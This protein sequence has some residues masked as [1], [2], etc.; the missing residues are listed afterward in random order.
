MTRMTRSR[1]RR[2]S[3]AWDECCNGGVGDDREVASSG[4]EILYSMT[5]PG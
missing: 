1:W 3:E 2:E 5:V 4:P